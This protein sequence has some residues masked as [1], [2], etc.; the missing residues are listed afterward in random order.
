MPWL[1]KI[2]QVK[3]KR[4]LFIFISLSRGKDSEKLYQF[5]R[6]YQIK[7]DIKGHEIFIENIN[8]MKLWL[9]IGEV[10]NY[11]NSQQLRSRGFSDRIQDG[12][13]RRDKHG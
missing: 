4:S 8:C 10:I 1:W 9:T 12:Y 7:D 5:Y 13:M 11:L 6:I 3:I 2:F